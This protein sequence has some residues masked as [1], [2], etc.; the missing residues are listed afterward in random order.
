M[1]K[2]SEEEYFKKGNRYITITLCHTG[3]HTHSRQ[4]V[5][6][7]S[8]ILHKVFHN[9]AIYQRAFIYAITTDDGNLRDNRNTDERG[10]N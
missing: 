3:D 5:V 2:T 6:N 10:D 1:Q 7:T 8:M 4:Q 9:T